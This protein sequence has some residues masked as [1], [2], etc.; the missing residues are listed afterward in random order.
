MSFKKSKGPRTGHSDQVPLP[1]KATRQGAKC[2]HTY[3]N[4]TDPKKTTSASQQSRAGQK[5]GQHRPQIATN[6]R[7]IAHQHLHPRS[8]RRKNVGTP[9]LHLPNCMPPSTAPNPKTERV[10]P[11]TACPT[12]N[13]AKLRP[14][15]LSPCRLSR[16]HARTATSTSNDTPKLH[17]KRHLH[18]HPNRTT[19]QLP[20]SITKQF[21]SSALIS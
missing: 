8:T 16:K 2:A 11:Q 15:P 19:K 13:L 10:A 21:P 5:N 1:A 20:K 7:M 6:K 9:R 3:F 14:H 18:Q 12:V 4:L 17:L